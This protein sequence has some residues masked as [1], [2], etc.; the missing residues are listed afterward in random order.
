[1]SVLGFIIP[2]KTAVVADPTTLLLL[3]PFLSPFKSTLVSD[4]V[5]RAFSSAALALPEAVRLRSKIS[6]ETD[7]AT[8]G[9]RSDVIPADIVGELLTS[10][11]QLTLSIA[12]GCIAELGENGIIRRGIV[13][14]T[15]LEGNK[16]RTLFAAF[17]RG[18]W[19]LEHTSPIKEVSK[20]VE[21]P[22]R[23]NTDG[24]KRLRKVPRGN[25]SAIFG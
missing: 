6:L 13:R 4:E 22:K 24:A 23:L 25:P 20:P 7:L 15:T 19:L 11:H 14:D 18:D 5:R 2:V 3:T 16:L 12:Q 17:E 1:M 9:K 10:T 21:R 8:K